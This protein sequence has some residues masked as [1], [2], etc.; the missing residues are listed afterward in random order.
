MRIILL[1]CILATMGCFI[2]P[3]I[4]YE[5]YED[6]YKTSKIVLRTPKYPLGDSYIALDGQAVTANVSASQDAKIIIGAEGKAK[7]LLFLYGICGIIVILG[8][9]AF[10]MPNQIVSNKDALII[11]GIGGVSF[12]VVR[13]VEA[14]APVMMWVVPIAAVC[15]GLYFVVIWLRKDKASPLIDK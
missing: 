2:S 13:W 8:V 5:Q 6:G 9:V 1:I 15:A 4:T 7:S 12:A 10:A 3:S 14:A 11:C